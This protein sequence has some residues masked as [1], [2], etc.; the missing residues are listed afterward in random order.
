MDECLSSA[1][2]IHFAV[3]VYVQISARST[4][5]LAVYR[6]ASMNGAQY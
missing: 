2:A 1:C 5:V 3:K 4:F 6:N